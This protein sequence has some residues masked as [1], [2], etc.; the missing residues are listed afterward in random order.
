MS[1]TTEHL[2]AAYIDLEVCKALHDKADEALQG[3]LEAS[4][5]P[6]DSPNWKFQEMATDVRLMLLALEGRLDTLEKNIIGAQDCMLR[7][8]KGEAA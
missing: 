4:A 2:D 6:K 3:I 8:A 1:T 5:G 7:P